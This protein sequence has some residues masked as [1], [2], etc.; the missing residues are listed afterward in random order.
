[1]HKRYDPDHL[2]IRDDIQKRLGEP[3]KKFQV[4]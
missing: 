3:G 4:V 1:M 2:R